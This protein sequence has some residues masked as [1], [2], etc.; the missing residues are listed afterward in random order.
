MNLASLVWHERVG[1]AIICACVAILGLAQS[2]VALAQQANTAGAPPLVVFAARAALAGL[3]PLT[4]RASTTLAALRSDPA[5]SQVRIGHSEPAPILAARALS[6]T[7]PSGAEVVFTGIDVRYNEDG[8]A[9]LYARDEATDTAL[10]LVIQG[11]DVV[12]SVRRGNETVN[13]RPLGDGMTAV[14]RF[15]ASRLPLHPMGW[16]GVMENRRAETDS[17][18]D[19]RAATASTDDGDVIDVMFAYTPNAKAEQGNI[20]AFIWLAIDNVNRAYANSEID[21]RLR[22]VHKHQ[23][24]YT[25]SS[26]L[27]TDLRRLTFSADD[28]ASDPQGD[29]DEIHSLR[30]RYGADLV[31]LLVGQ[32]TSS[33]GVAWKPSYRQLSDEDH[34]YLGFSVVAQNCESLT[35]P[36]VAHEIGHNLGAS[37]DPDN[38]IGPST[39]PY[40]HGFCNHFDDW[41]TVMAYARNEQGLCIHKIPYFSS[42]VLR[43]R[44]TPTGDA[45]TRDNRRVLMETAR[46]VANFRQS[47]GAQRTVYSL[48]LVTRASDV[49]RQGFVRIVNHSLRSGSVT[50]HA[51][52]DD[53]RRR[54]PLS[55]VLEPRGAVHLNS[56]DIE[57]GNPD[58]GLIGRTGESTGHWRMEMTTDLEIE[59]LAYIRTA[60]GFVTSM[61][62]VAAEV[63]DDSNRY[64]V[65]FFNPGKNG[66]QVSI[67]RLINPGID[68]ASIEITGVDDRGL[69]PPFGAARLTLAGGMARML[70]ASEL[71]E[72]SPRLLGR[73]GAGEGKWRLSVSADRP[74]Q[75][76]NLLQLP[77]G[78][79]TNLSFG[80][81]EPSFGTIPLPTGLAR[82]RITDQCTDGRRF[83][84]RFFGLDEEGVHRETWPDGDAFFFTSGDGE[85]DSHALNCAIGTATVCYGARVDGLDGGVW[86]VDVDRSRTCRGCCQRCTTEHVTRVVDLRCR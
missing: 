34:S 49:A 48:P 77:T 80:Y 24:N 69:A 14:Y 19:Q 46:R 23:V 16:T 18:Q 43:Y 2:R 28:G 27:G 50:I 38:R 56:H 40:G 73:L 42:P 20:D 9:S 45:V 61:N 33:C 83:K 36:A 7:L 13:I 21:F 47:K 66:N 52:D 5:A 67:L 37:H 26:H 68:T 55:L 8:F 75:L 65:P 35:S 64:H 25:Q 54:G 4:A 15:D 10:A 44:G 86:G 29:M 30:D 79:L 41:R 39:F 17:D 3:A 58:K 85:S 53:G 62:E 31:V 70:T 57:H 84:Y 76:M 81:G 11:Q 59:P 63:Q 1:T 72:G 60:D 6:L 32:N 78:H 71:E 12:G 74:L 51:I 22:L 82:W